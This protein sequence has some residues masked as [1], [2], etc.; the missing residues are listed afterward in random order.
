MSLGHLPHVLRESHDALL[1]RAEL[2]ADVVERRERVGSNALPLRAGVA[3][4]SEKLPTVT[5][6]LWQLPQ[7]AVRGFSIALHF[8][9]LV[10][11]TAQP[12]LHESLYS[13]HVLGVWGVS[14]EGAI[15]SVAS[16]R[17]S[18]RV[19]FSPSVLALKFVA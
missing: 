14:S 6:A 4:L 19:S 13:E 2:Q 1:V 3:S 5:D 8:I 11:S 17:N 9:Y 7:A 15:S 18:R 12:G 16:A 10:L